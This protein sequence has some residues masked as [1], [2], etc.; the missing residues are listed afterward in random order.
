MDPI[1]NMITIIKNGYLAKKRVV[2]VPHSVLKREIAKK[3]QEIGYIE[4]FTEK[5]DERRLEINLLYEGYQ[6]AV[7]EV[8]RISKPSLRVY[9]KSANIP[10]I[11]RGRGEVL[12]S[13]PKGIMTGAEARKARIGGEL[14]LKIW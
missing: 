14:L 9:S 2:S 3:L 4:S 8:K 11:L 12:L 6:P 10:R 13:T 5:K 7:R 1:A